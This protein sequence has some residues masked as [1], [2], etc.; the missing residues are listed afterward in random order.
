MFGS[1]YENRTTYQE[2]GLDKLFFDSPFGKLDKKKQKLF[3]NLTLS[4]LTFYE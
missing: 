2:Y 4:I 3:F 1:G